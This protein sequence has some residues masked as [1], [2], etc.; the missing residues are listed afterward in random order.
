MYYIAICD[1]NSDF[2]RYMKNMLLKSGLKN[3][4]VFFYEYNSGE[5]LIKSIN[6][7]DKI[8][9]L[10]LDMQMKK[11]DGNGTARLFRNQFPSSV[12]VFCS[13]V[14]LP[15]VESFETTP[16]RYLLKEY[17]DERMIRDA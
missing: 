11:L 14:Y 2:I 8:D 17:T 5:E 7:C 9:L 10:I 6:T 16:F 4:E 12:M 15:T 13:G 3:E 1:D